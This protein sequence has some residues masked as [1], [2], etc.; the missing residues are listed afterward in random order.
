MF[1]Y[2]SWRKDHDTSHY[3]FDTDFILYRKRYYRMSYTSIYFQRYKTRILMIVQRGDEKWTVDVVSEV[4][5]ALLQLMGDESTSG[6]QSV[7]MT[8]FVMENRLLL[9]LLLSATPPSSPSPPRMENKLQKLSRINSNF[10]SAIVLVLW[11]ILF[12]ELFIYIYI[13]FFSSIFFFSS[14]V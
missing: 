6:D 4:C 12:L 2:T 9:S 3:D 11:Y 8:A 5:S 10:I 7:K 14:K 1:Q 13:L